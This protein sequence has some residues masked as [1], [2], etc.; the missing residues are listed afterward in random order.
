[1]QNSC[2]HTIKWLPVP[3][4]NDAV[5]FILELFE[6]RWFGLSFPNF[7]VV[8][9]LDDTVRIPELSFL[10]FR[11]GD[12]SARHVESSNLLPSP[13]ERVSPRRISVGTKMC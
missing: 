8:S 1:M 9:I 10:S 7:A 12:G 5:G 6:S 4:L 11:G 2:V 13:C 3:I